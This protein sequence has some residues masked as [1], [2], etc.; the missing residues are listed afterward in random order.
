M[1]VRI[2][3]DDVV[4]IGEQQVGIGFPSVSCNDGRQGGEGSESFRMRVLQRIGPQ[5]L[6]EDILRQRELK[7]S[8]TLQ[9]ILIRNRRK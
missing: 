1:N 2:F 5:M 3:Y 8:D 7:Q 4:N 6:V 9:R